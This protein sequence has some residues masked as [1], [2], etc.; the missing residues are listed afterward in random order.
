MK[1]HPSFHTLNQVTVQLF[2]HLSNQQIGSNQ[3]E[4]LL[5]QVQWEIQDG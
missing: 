2:N 5:Y 4:K 3:S 1:I